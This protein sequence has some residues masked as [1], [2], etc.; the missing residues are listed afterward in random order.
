MAFRFKRRE[1]IVDGVLRIANEQA[2]AIARVLLLQK[3]GGGGL[4]AGQIH[5]ARV[6]LKRLRALARLVRGELGP[7]VFRRADTSFRD[8]ARALAP[9]RS[10]AMLLAAFD[11]VVAGKNLPSFPAMRAAL[12]DA[13]RTSRRT[14]VPAVARRDLATQLH[15]TI[16]AIERVQFAFK[17]WDACRDELQ[18]NYRKG[19]NAAALIAAATTTE[20]LHD[21]RRRVKD[22]YFQ[23]ALFERLP[24]ATLPAMTR[25]AWR[26]SEY[27]G[28][29]HDVALLEVFVRRSGRAFAKIPQLDGLLTA[30]ATHRQRLQKKAFRIA[31]R[32]YRETPRNFVA[33]LADAW[34]HWRMRRK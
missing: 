10:A 11:A 12:A 19:R 3:P 2:E 31:A 8:I 15:E 25:D 22:L 28:D 33:R 29:E 17:G 5:K 32:L 30:I 34:S 27:L 13:A 18:L 20:A 14:P 16:I 6:R 1:T 4:S 26:L 21:W 9:T 24:G 7:Q 23:L